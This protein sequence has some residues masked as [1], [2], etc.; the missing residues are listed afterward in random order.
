MSEPAETPPS[1]GSCL[2]G[3]VRFTIGGRPP[4]VGM[5]HCSKCRK[6]SGVGSNAVLAVRRERLTWLA[7][8]DSLASFNLPDSPW[9][10]TFCA[11]C[12][13]PAPRLMPNGE[14]YWVPAGLLDADPGPAVAGHIFVGSKASWDVIGDDAPQFDEFPDGGT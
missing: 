7:G 11:T 9:G 5:C 3:A 1:P 14:R 6:A 10:T 8:E 2:C 13:C 12:G 4:P